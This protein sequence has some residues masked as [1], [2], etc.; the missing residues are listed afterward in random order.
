M[1]REAWIQRQEVLPSTFPPLLPSLDLVTCSCGKLALFHV[2]EQKRGGIKIACSDSV[3]SVEFGGGGSMEDP[4]TSRSTSS[5]KSGVS[6]KVKT[7]EGTQLGG[8]IELLILRFRPFQGLWHR[9]P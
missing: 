8:E 2:E 6:F 4:T 3:S 1:R 5:G 7:S 9:F